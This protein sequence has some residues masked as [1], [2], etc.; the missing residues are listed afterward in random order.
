[1]LF[2]TV[3]SALFCSEQLY[4]EGFLPDVVVVVAAGVSVK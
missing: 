1:M 3:W 2:K 4:F